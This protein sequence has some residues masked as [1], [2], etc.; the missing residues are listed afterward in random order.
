MIVRVSNNGGE[1]PAQSPGTFV[2]NLLVALH[3]TQA[4]ASRKTDISSAILG[5]WMRDEMDPGIKNARK[6]ADGLG[7][8]R[9]FV[10]FGL[11]I[12][13]PKDV[14]FDASFTRLME[15]YALTQAESERGRMREQIDFIADMAK[16]R[17][18]DSQRSEELGED[19]R[20]A[21]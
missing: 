21:G 11:Q 2:R 18:L 7:V 12:L 9:L 19:E 4:S 3:E 5:R 1:G 15:V 14:N 6:F 8:P 16:K 13:E 10:L 17:F 20:E